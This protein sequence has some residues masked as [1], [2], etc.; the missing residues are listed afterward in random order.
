MQ[1]SNIAAYDKYFDKV[2]DA[3]EIS[4][5][6]FA[7]QVQIRLLEYLSTQYCESTAALV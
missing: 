3:S 4:V 1:F 7:M 6:Q 2:V 5:E